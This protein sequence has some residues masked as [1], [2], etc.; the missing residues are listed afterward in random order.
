[1]QILNL[2]E[3]YD[4]AVLDNETDLPAARTNQPPQHWVVFV[5]TEN[6]D[7]ELE[8]RRKVWES[9]A[10]T[11]TIITTFTRASWRVEEKSIQNP[12]RERFGF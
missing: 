12:L 2:K 9:L 8:Q 11:T 6:L 10:T 5:N 3:E 7:Q 1:M 4:E